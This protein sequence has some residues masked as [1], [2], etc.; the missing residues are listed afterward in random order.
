M[1]TLFKKIKEDSANQLIEIVKELEN[2]EISVGTDLHDES[3]N[4]TELEPQ[5]ADI[6]NKNAVEK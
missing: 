1:A 4:L 6:W 5:I 3:D 2:R